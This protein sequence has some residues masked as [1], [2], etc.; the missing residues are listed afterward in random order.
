M[1]YSN[2]QIRALFLVPLS[3][4]FLASLASC[5][6]SQGEPVYLGHNYFG[7]T[8]G[9]WVVYDVDSTVYD[10]FLGEVFHYQYQVL[11]TYTDYFIDNQGDSVLRIERFYR[12]QPTDTW[13]IKNVWSSKL[14]ISRAVKTEE[15]RSFIKLAFPVKRNQ[16]WNGN[17]LN[18][19]PA[20]T[21]TI[22]QAHIPEQFGEL[23]F[24]S[25]AT[26]LQK[27]FETLIGLDLQYEVYATQVGM[28]KKKFVELTKEI[29][30]TIV[31]GVD[32]TYIINSYGYR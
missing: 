19:L 31:R 27:D 12:L 2:R 18:T 14:L 8:P 24:D 9:L 28:V 29:D 10:D 32:Y 5:H 6:K 3:M 7:H 30:G 26:V 15:N 1:R 13:Q 20:Q 21:Y 16:N 17:A 25:T 4:I 23:L 22:T 11:E